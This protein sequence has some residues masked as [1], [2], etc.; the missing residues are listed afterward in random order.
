MA[1]AKKAAKKSAAKKPAAKKTAAKKPAAKK[2]AAK[3]PAAKKSA[4]KKPAAKKTARQAQAEC[5][6]HESDAAVVGARRS[7]R[8]HA[9]AAHRSDEEDLGLHQ[10]EQAAGRA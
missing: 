9:D 3:K 10:E 1:T 5:G 8:R 4:A 2:S 7:R 6:V